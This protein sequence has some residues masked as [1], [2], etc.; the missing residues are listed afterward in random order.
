MKTNTGDQSLMRSQPTTIVMQFPR[1]S[2]GTSQTA[3][4]SKAK[5]RVKVHQFTPADDRRAIAHAFF[6]LGKSVRWLAKM[7]RRSECTIEE[8][9]RS[10][11]DA[12]LGT[13]RHA[14]GL[15]VVSPTQPSGPGSMRRVA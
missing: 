8:I 14:A 15:I 7:A 2:A 10:S 11:H 12:Q 4:F 13:L 6:V 9:I 3:E 1:Q 5:Q